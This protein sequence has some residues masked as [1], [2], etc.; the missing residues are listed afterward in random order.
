MIAQ[1]LLLPEINWSEHVRTKTCGVYML[2]L[3]G[4]IQYIGKSKDVNARIGE[5]QALGTIPF[6]LV[7]VAVVPP[8]KLDEIERA[9]IVKHQPPFNRT[10]TERFKLRRKRQNMTSVL[11]AKL[12]LELHARIVRIGISKQASLRTVSSYIREAVVEIVEHEERKLGLSPITEHEV[13]M[14]LKKAA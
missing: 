14:A 2:L 4:A 11:R 8:S 10:H 3:V 9:L 13:A 7:K 6:D 1:P 12:P 5:H